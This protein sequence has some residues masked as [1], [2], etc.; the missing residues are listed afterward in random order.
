MMEIKN[1]KVQSTRLGLSGP[2]L[3]FWLHLDYGGVVQGF[4]GFGLI[5]DSDGKGTAF[6]AAAIRAALK[7]CDTN[8]WEKLA[9][10]SVRVKLERGRIV[11]IGHF[12]KE[13]W[14][15]LDVLLEAYSNET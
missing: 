11:A 7:V 3:L 9:G 13:E 12:L 4:G 6:G 8:E 5:S 1:A 14:L 10:Q 15:D 2:N